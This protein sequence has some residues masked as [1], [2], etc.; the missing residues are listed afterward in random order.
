MA[1]VAD[2]W[3]LWYA[4]VQLNRNLPHREIAVNLLVEAGE[5]A[6][7]GTEF[8][9]ACLV[10]ALQG[11][12]PE[13]EVWVYRVLNEHR[14]VYALKTVGKCLHGEWVG[15]STCAYPQ[16]VDSIF[17]RELY[18]LWGS[19]LSSCQHACFFLHLLHPRQGLLAVTLE[20]SRFGAW[21]PHTCAEHV[22]TF[23][24][25][26][27]SG[28]HHLLFSLC[29]ARAGNDARAFLITRKIQWF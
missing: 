17:Q 21:L 25:Q 10:D 20:A 8:L 2:D 13:L 19:H 26:L 27:L 15:R 1:R 29:R 28:S 12:D 22:A 24:S 7:D 16:N 5:S 6:V 3:Q 9:D 4:A 11:T 18:M 14:H 23:G